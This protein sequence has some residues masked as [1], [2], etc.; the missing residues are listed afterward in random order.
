MRFLYIFLVAALF[1]V[2]YAATLS[3]DTEVEELEIPHVREKRT[4]LLKKKLALVGGA[5]IAKKVIGAK[6]LG[7]GVLGAGVLGAGVLGA[8]LY[9]AK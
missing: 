4:L 2:A 8:G 3:K 9:K 5:L 6:V 7:A 1:A